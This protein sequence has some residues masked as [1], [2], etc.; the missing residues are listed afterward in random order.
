[1]MNSLPHVCP[2]RLAVLPIKPP[3]PHLL[4]KV[5][6]ALTGAKD[7]QRSSLPIAWLL[8]LAQRLAPHV[9]S[10][11]EVIVPGPALTLLGFGMLIVAFPLEA[12][13]AGLAWVRLLQSKGGIS[14][15]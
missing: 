15:S 2:A 5:L 12:V 11:R 1:M 6:G 13:G 9:P 14:L 10:W 7:G 4:F 3:V 8:R